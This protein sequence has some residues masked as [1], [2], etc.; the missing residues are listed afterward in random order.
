MPNSGIAL[1]RCGHE[2]GHTDAAGQNRSRQAPKPVETPGMQAWATSP[3]RLLPESARARARLEGQDLAQLAVKGDRLAVEHHRAHARLEQPRHARR[4]VGVLLR[5]VLAVAAAARRAA[6]SSQRAVIQQVLSHC[7]SS[8][9]SL[10]LARSHAVARTRPCRSCCAAA[11]GGRPAWRLS[12][13]HL[14]HAGH[15]Q[16][17]ST[18]V[19]AQTPWDNA[20]MNSAAA[21]RL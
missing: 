13:V 18:Q 20:G 21:A 17:K 5:V 14:Q 12:R 6:R 2:Q 15:M 19:Q 8:Q 10:S 4:D 1:A 9:G 16:E 7:A 11:T 3:P